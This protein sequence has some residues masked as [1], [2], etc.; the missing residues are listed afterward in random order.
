MQQQRLD[1][2]LDAVK[3]PM[4]FG[5]NYFTN[6]VPDF[7]YEGMREGWGKR[8]YQQEAYGRFVHY[9]QKKPSDVP[10]HL[11][12]HM[13]TGSGKTLIMAGLIVYL[14]EQG[15]RNFLFFV[16]SSNI[17][18]KTKENFLNPQFGKYLYAENIVVNHR[19]IHIKEVDNF[20]GANEDDINIVFQTIQG[21]HYDLNNPKENSLTYED[22]KN[23]KIVLISD[24]AHH[25]N[26]STKKVKDRNADELMNEI[27]WENTVREIFK[28][29][30]ENV[31]L[32]FTATVD[33]ENENIKEKY[34]DKL[35]FDYP[36]RQFRNDGY[37]KEVKTLSA[38]L[39]EFERALQGLI[40]SQ[41]RRKIFEKNGLFVKP[42]ILFKSKTIKESAAFFQT[43]HERM[44]QLDRKDLQA[45]S[46]NANRFN[47]QANLFDKADRVL[48]EAF[49]F[50][51]KRGIS[52]ENL[53]IEL[54]ED[55]SEEKCIIVNSKSESEEKQLAV[56]SLEDEF[57]EYR[58]VF[59]VDKLNEGWDVLNL[60]DIVRLYN[61]RDAKKGKPG[62]TTMSEA[63]LIGRGA[64][65]C[66]FQLNEEQPRYQR[67]YDDIMVDDE[68]AK[69]LKVCEELY[70]HAE[71]NPRYIQELNTAL[72]KIGIKPKTTKEVE[73]K[74]KSEFEKSSFYQKAF[75]FTNRRI[76]NDN[77]DIFKLKESIIGHTHKVDLLTGFTQTET[78]FKDAAITQKV[79]KKRKDFYLKDFGKSIVHKALNQFELYKFSVLRTYLPHLKSTTEFIESENYLGKIK[80]EVSGSPAQIKHLSNRN[81]Y[82]IAIQVLDQIQPKIMAENVEFKGAK[83][84]EHYLL[85]DTIKDKT[86]N[87]A[88]DDKSDKQ[89][90]KSMKSA[91]NPYYLN[92]EQKDWYA[93]EDCF[94][95]SEEKAMIRYVDKMYDE[96]KKQYDEIYLVRNER[97]FKVYT[98]NEGL[99]FEPDFV[100]YLSKN[101]G[102]KN[103]HY[104]IFIEPKGGQLLE[105]GTEATKESFLLA[106]KNEHK[107]EQIWKDKKYIVW[108]LP[109]YN[110]NKE[111]QFDEAF[112]QNLIE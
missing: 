38:E 27:S 51:Q 20:E 36:L 1:K 55:F 75:I 98:F 91:D 15:Y 34:N 80:V 63:Q 69:E 71:Y 42:V 76:K 8:P 61:T 6:L 85:K 58:A 107:L 25:I 56:N 100:L 18:R 23:K 86:L 30:P 108:G 12:Y 2:Q 79:D 26:A 78:I 54:K 45:I 97:H 28:S 87:F 66:P 102:S 74:L 93:F 16:N 49:E 103:K 95:T 64:R 46:D 83:K 40:L 111:Q 101:E 14:Y 35:I 24:E 47:L 43:F 62:K 72:E 88:I 67:K 32:E 10:V 37:S 90:G 21:L 50:F 89:I 53:I 109:F 110:E 22:F 99:A 17:I 29:H 44:K 41:Y 59:A 77:Q 57:N 11:L 9:W 48:Y 19:Q 81:K 68:A 3:S 96:L 52:M 104:Q 70:Y 92:L 60:F 5:E 94:G 106:L 39:S 105:K 31:M 33:L 82:K 7:L 73:L 112:Q 65:Y 13:A 84:F 4:V